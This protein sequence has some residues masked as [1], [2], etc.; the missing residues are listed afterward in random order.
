VLIHQPSYSLLNRW[1]EE[2]VL[3]VVGE[4]LQP[5]HAGVWLRE[6]RP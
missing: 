3:D 2:D 5:A 4:T 1:I 6:A